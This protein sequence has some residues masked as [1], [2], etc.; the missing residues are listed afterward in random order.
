[1]LLINTPFMLFSHAVT[2]RVRVLY[3]PAL[4]M[5]TVASMLCFR[6]AKVSLTLYVPPGAVPASRLMSDEP[7][8]RVTTPKFSE[9]SLQL[10][11]M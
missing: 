1:M 8:A 6:S 10:R 9:A 4:F 5:L 2:S 3:T 7:S 11:P